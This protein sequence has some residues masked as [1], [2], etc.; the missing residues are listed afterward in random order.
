MRNHLQT[1]EFGCD[2]HIFVSVV[3]NIG[4]KRLWEFTDGPHYTY[5]EFKGEF[6]GTLGKILTLY[7]RGKRM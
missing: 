5:S 6:W 2:L 3:R 4:K 1:L 7:D